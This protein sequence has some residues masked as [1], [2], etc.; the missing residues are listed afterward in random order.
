[1]LLILITVVPF[2]LALLSPLAVRLAGPYRSW[3]GWALAAASLVLLAFGL[4]YLPDLRE[5][6][7]I[8]RGIAW[9][10]QIGLSLRW[11]LD[12]LSL[13]FVLLITGIGTAIALYAGYYFDAAEE[14]ARFYLY[15]MA[16]MGS[17]LLL[18]LAGNLLTLFIAWE[19]TS[20]ISFLLIGFKGRKE[21]AARQGAL[22]ALIVTGGGG[23][24]LIAALVLMGTA[25]GSMELKDILGGGDFLRAHPWYPAITILLL[26]GAFTKSAQFPFHFWLP[27]AMAAPSPAS[28][29]LHSATMV[30]AGVYL[31]AR[32]Y[33][34]LGGTPLWEISLLTAGLA[35]L[36]VGSM[37]ALRQNDLKAILAY[38][39]VSALGG[40]IALIG[41]PDYAGLKAAYIGIVA[42]ALYKCTLFLVAGI[43]DHQTGTRDIRHLNGLWNA[44]PLAGVVTI[45]AALS[46][47][48]V[49]PLIGFVAK[50]TLLDAFL[51]EGLVMWIVLV[52]VAASLTVAVSLILVWD[53]FFGEVSAIDTHHIHHMP[54]AILVGPGLLAAGGLFVGLLLPKTIIP[55]LTVALP[56]P[57][58]LVLFPG[59]N[60]AFVL[61]SAAIIVGI[62]V[63]AL[64][65]LWRQWEFPL[66][67]A[68]DAYRLTIR[69][70]E[71]AGTLLLQ[72]QNGKL[73]LYLQFILSAIAI[74][75]LTT[76]FV[77]MPSAGHLLEPALRSIRIDSTTDV[78][79]ATLLILTVAAALGTVL[80]KRHITA[81][82]SLG[83]MGYAIGGVFV[84]EP[85]PDVALV[86]IL[87]ETLGTVMII[88]MLARISLPQRQL[89]HEKEWHGEPQIVLVRNIILSVVTGA[90]V[91]FFALTAVLTRP[92]RTSIAEWY[93]DNTY[94]NLGVT[95]IV[96]AIVTDFRGTD[97]LIE[98]S[99]F[100]A[101]AVG[102]LTLLSSIR[103]I[104][105][106]AGQ[107][108]PLTVRTGRSNQGADVTLMDSNLSTPLTRVVTSLLLPFALLI[109]LSHIL[110]GGFRPGDGFT[111]GVI[112]GLGVS[113][114]YI[115]FGYEE[116]RQRLKWFHP[117]RLVGVGIALA[118][119]NALMPM[120]F[121]QPFLGF[122]A[123]AVA[124]PADLKLASTTLFEAAIFLTVSGAIGTIMEAIT[125]PREVEQL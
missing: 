90:V 69:G 120:L 56:K 103:R 122:V 26:G 110:Y 55:L 43:I 68:E 79:E 73:R 87:V 114:W 21:P 46:M 118:V 2:V 84:L 106:M 98:I 102:L 10:P 82:L 59:F 113:S 48:G 54:G 24:M 86:Q 92:D 88:M 121:G 70:I 4:Q 124:L 45:V 77:L 83:V 91:T 71:Q 67:S 14:Q 101:A 27:G 13:L 17:M 111:A 93:L 112:A 42:H 3:I 8:E 33:P 47:A 97:T 74:F 63:F 1:M 125:H 12:G 23:L 99:V 75:M 72:S 22:Q 34:V 58:E 78:L 19:L 65:G 51:E 38:T 107:E 49:I 117:G 35:T 85:A 29:Y 9:V 104:N 11:Y 15:L 53:V 66:P 123:L 94:A 16:F 61:S 20:I 62:G 5:V 81:A 64:R 115:V 60:T 50:E 89:I 100:G 116:A 36:L 76:R 109:S 31:L 95:D 28:A 96:A 39:T 7:F 52:M 30:K 25:T 80:F 119:G 32:M 18:V 108:N 41:L 40:L 57:F 44:M 37:L 105:V 6:G